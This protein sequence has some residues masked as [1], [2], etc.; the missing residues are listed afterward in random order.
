MI[1]AEN[2]VE[3]F[4]TDWGGFLG[5]CDTMPVE[6]STYRQLWGTDYFVG[7]YPVPE[8]SWVFLASCH[9]NL[10]DIDLVDEERAVLAFRATMSIFSKST[11]SR[12]VSAVDFRN[13][14]VKWLSQL[15][16][17]ALD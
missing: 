9:A 1:L 4:D 13:E 3:H 2:E 16:S 6:E 12:Y 10:K 8:R 5:W 17:F 7:L 11:S 14:S 15:I